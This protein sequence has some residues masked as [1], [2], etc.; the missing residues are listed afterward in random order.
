MTDFEQ[1]R[2]VITRE[3]ATQLLS[4][5]ACPDC[6]KVGDFQIFDEI[7]NNGRGIRCGSCGKHHPFIKQ[8]IMWLRGEKKR[9]SNDIQAVANECG[10]YCYGCGASF[11]ELMDWGIGLHVHHTRGFAAT[12]EQFKKI[13]VCAECHELLNFMQRIRQRQRNTR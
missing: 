7:N 11:R 12:A 1:L 4:D 8:Q 5:V 10:A 3:N 13:P 9:Q 2:T 6:G